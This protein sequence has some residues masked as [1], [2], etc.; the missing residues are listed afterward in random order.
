MRMLDLLCYVTLNYDLSHDSDIRFRSGF[1]L[2]VS[3]EGKV[4]LSIKVSELAGPKLNFK[5]F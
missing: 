5:D 3:Q 4:S 1:D 2:A